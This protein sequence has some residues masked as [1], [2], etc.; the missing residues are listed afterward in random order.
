MELL[1]DKFSF[2]Q[3]GVAM[4]KN[5]PNA[6]DLLMNQEDLQKLLAQ[7]TSTTSLSER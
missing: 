5:S 6:N 7:N 2:K 1:S 4:K 3:A